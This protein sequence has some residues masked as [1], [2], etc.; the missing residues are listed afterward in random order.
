MDPESG[1]DDQ[2]SE[3]DGEAEERRDSLCGVVVSDEIQHVV[4][5]AP[6]P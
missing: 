2:P 3:A 5:P 4:T 6:H 1:R